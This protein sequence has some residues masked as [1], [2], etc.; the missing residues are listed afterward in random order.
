[1]NIVKYKYPHQND[2]VEIDVN[3]YDFKTIKFHHLINYWCMLCKPIHHARNMIKEDTLM[4]IKELFNQSNRHK[5]KHGDTIMKIRSILYTLQ[6]LSSKPSSSNTSSLPLLPSLLSHSTNPTSN[7][8]SSSESRDSTSQADS[9]F[10]M[11][12]KN[13]FERLICH[14]IV[15]TLGCFK[16]QPLITESVTKVSYHNVKRYGSVY[17]AIQNFYTSVCLDSINPDFNNYNTEWHD[18]EMYYIVVAPTKSGL[19]FVYDRQNQQDFMFTL[20]SRS[21][22]ISNLSI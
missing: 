13:S 9:T 5:K 21:K 20:L 2:V 7:L 1:M 10:Q 16:T 22:T 19:K 17:K 3:I 11:S 15:D 6:E 8:D 14:L 12:R 4:T 18:D